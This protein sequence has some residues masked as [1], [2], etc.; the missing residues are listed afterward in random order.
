MVFSLRLRRLQTA[1]PQTLVRRRGIALL[2][3]A[4]TARGVVGAGAATG[5]R[6]PLAGLVPPLGVLPAAA[7][8]GAAVVVGRGG[9]RPGGGAEMRRK[10]RFI[11]GF[12]IL[13]LNFR[14]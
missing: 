10:L 6:L 3:L 14:D 11:I 9:E 4:A 8:L 5:G 12:F 7:R 1:I 13:N 2:V